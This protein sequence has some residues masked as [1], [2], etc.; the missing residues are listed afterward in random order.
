MKDQIANEARI[1][2]YRGEIVTSLLILVGCFGISGGLVSF[3]RLAFVKCV[4]QSWLGI[5]FN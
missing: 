1:F 4:R 3:L 2:M 5:R